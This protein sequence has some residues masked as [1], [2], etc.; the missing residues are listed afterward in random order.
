M[1]V[2][3]YRDANYA[4]SSIRLQ[5]GFYSGRDEL[6]GGTRG[7]SYE[8]DL[9]NE[10]SSIRVDAGYIAVL[11]AGLSASASGGGARTIVGPSEIPDLSA[12]GM[13]DKTSAVQVYMFEEASSA[14]PRDFGVSLHNTTY[15]ASS[16]GSHRVGGIHIGQ[17][18]Y[19]RTR[20][21]SDEVKIGSSGVRGLCVGPNTL[22][23]L[24]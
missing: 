23:I 15:G 4:G 9:S 2:I 16:A 13:N 7:S 21:D 22:A 14:L 8:E 17:G 1:P 5:P 3:L 11:Y 24:Y 12:V 19:D 6:Q 18:S 10:I 20:L